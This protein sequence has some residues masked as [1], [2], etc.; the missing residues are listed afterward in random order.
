MQYSFRKATEK[1]LNQVWD[2]LQDAIK[3]RR[4]EGSNQWQ[5]GYPNAEVIQKDVEKDGGYVLTDGETIAGYCAI[6]INDEP[7]YANIKGE[8][9]TDGDFVLYHRVAI[10]EKYLGQGLA[11]RMLRHVEDFARTSNIWSVKADTNFDNIGMLRIFEKMGY[12]YCGEVTFRGSARK[13][14]EKVLDE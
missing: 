9:L 6:F 3:R 8:W 2:I 14:F 11:Q 4:E 12:T 1:D 5:D 13:A 7:E 10:S